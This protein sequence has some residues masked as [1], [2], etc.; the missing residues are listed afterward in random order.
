MTGMAA[1][2]FCG[3]F[4]SCSRDTDLGGSNPQQSIQETYE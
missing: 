2:V 4:T 3:V 1:M